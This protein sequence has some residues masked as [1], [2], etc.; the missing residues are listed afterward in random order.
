MQTKPRKS[1][2]RRLKLEDQ[3]SSTSEM[4]KDVLHGLKQTPKWLP[5]RYLYDER[6]SEL[7]ERICETPEYYPTRTEIGILESAAR[8]IAQR[9]GPG[10]VLIEPGAGAS[11]KVRILLDHL[12]SIAGLVLV[13]I[14]G[15]HLLSAA[16]TLAAD[17]PALKIVPVSADFL[18]PIDIPEIADARRRVVFF[19][20][21]TIGN[22]P[23]DMALDV[24]MAFRADVGDDGGLLI[25]VDLVKDAKTLEA[26]YDDAGGVTRAFTFNLLSR[27]NRELKANFD[28][29]KFRYQA[30]F[31]T[32]LNRIES[33][34]ISLSE[35]RVRIGNHTVRLTAGERIRT[36]VSQKFTL[37][38]FAELARKAAFE[39]EQVWR[40]EKAWFSVQYL[41]AV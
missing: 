34:V 30:R 4:L 36:E 35:Q 23:L 17:Y 32:T 25:G 14:S 13:D 40:D 20:G 39:V 22:F 26:A 16:Q 27:L 21:S 6:G 38:S 7:F 2:T 15:D 37:D 8:E 19:P 9:I 10:C 41:R 1:A 33:G 11:Q 24:L 12:E 3:S 31:N 28:A 5:S 18:R 29:N